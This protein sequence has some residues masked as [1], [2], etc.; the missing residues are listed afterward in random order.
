M[1]RPT[2]QPSA[3]GHAGGTRD[4]LEAAKTR[5]VEDHRVEE[6]RRPRSSSSR[7]EAESEE[8]RRTERLEMEERVRRVRE[9]ARARTQEL[10][11]SI[12]AVTNNT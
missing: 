10:V 4:E 12:G 1:P 11:M 8:R 3:L 2:R 7:G 6:E 9:K 5:K